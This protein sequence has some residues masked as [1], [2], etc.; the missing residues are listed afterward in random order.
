MHSFI[1][2][3]TL[4][5]IHS[6][7]HSF[8]Y[9]FVSSYVHTFV[10]N[11]L[12]QLFIHPFA[13]SSIA[14]IIQSLSMSTGLHYSVFTL[15]PTISLLNHVKPLLHKITLYYY[16]ITLYYTIQYHIISYRIVSY[17]ITLYSLISYYRRISSQLRLQLLG[18][19]QPEL[20]M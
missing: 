17:R 9:S 13:L 2:S 18:K 16:Y 5:F 15:T 7:M 11:S 10:N 20:P 3:F 8:I 14:W 19:L 6:L 1:H 4:F 12:V